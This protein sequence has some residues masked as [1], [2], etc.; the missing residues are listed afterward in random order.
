MD[1]RRVHRES[2]VRGA[3]VSGTRPADSP[4]SSGAKR[5]RVIEAVGGVYTVELDDGRELPTRL[6]GS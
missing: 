3:S 6:R 2:D 4:P 5:G 1:K